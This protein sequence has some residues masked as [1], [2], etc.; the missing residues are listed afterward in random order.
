M[1]LLRTVNIVAFNLLVLGI[2]FAQHLPNSMTITGRVAI[3]DGSVLP[4]PAAILRVCNGNQHTEGYTATGG[5]FRVLFAYEEDVFQDA[6]ESGRSATVNRVPTTDSYESS[7]LTRR[8]MSCELKASL[9]GFRSQTI[10][11]SGR[12]PANVGTILL[13]RTNNSDEGTTVS[14]VSLAAPKNARKAFDKGVDLQK[15]N[16]AD[17]AIRQFQKAVALYPTYATAWYK[18]GAIEFGSGKL[19][20]ARDAF[21]KAAQADPKFVAPYVQL[22]RLEL[23]AQ[24]WPELAE[25]TSKALTLDPFDYPKEFLFDSVAQYHLHNF[26]RAEKSILRAEAL[27][28]RHEFPQIVYMKGLLLLQHQDYIAA[29][30]SLR[31]YLKLAPN[32]DDAAKVR[33]QLEEVEKNA[34]Q[35]TVKR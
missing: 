35:T 33:E 10:L 27:D 30:E 20:S 11:V 26:D 31:T 25:C 28:T 22:S 14:T 9:S 29:A 17:A 32:A 3:D 16:K 23:R 24:R 4:E 18:I 12:P 8:L 5:D 7:A 13:H 21:N 6:S 34:S 19:E 1:L 15:E 2:G